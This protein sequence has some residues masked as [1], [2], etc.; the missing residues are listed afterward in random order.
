MHLFCRRASS[1]FG[2]GVILCLAID[3]VATLIAVALGNGLPLLIILMTMHPMGISFFLWLFL[4]FLAWC[5]RP[6][7]ES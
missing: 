3:L 4:G 1:F 7:Y 6:E 5:S 2:W